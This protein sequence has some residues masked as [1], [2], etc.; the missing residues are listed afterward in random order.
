MTV[1]L[2]DGNRPRPHIARTI[3]FVTKLV[4]QAD[5]RQ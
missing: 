2:D 4:D 1:D 3:G 5:A